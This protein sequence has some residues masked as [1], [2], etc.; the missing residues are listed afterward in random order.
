MV[1]QRVAPLAGA[2]IETQSLQNVVKCYVAPLAGAWIET[3]RPVEVAANADVAPLAGAWIETGLPRL[4]T[5]LSLVAPL[6]GA[7]IETSSVGKPEKADLKSHPSRVRGLKPAVSCIYSGGPGRTP[8][9]C[10]D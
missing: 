10:V 3:Y 5:G 2:W 7:W 9:G 4:S 1:S 6:A 8:R